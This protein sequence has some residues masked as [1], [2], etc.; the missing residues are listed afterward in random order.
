MKQI[1]RKFARL[2]EEE[3]KLSLEKCQ[4]YRTSVTHPGHVVSVSLRTDEVESSHYLA[5][6]GDGVETPFWILFLLLEIYGEFNKNCPSPLTNC[7]NL[8]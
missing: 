2:H 7:F 5:E 3:W 1:W 8:S 4:L 6:D